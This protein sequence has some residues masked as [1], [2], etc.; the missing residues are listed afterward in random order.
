MLTLI[1]M[2]AY[3]YQAINELKRDLEHVRDVDHYWIT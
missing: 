1:S 2:F 3:A